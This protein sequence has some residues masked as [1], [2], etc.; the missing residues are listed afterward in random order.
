MDLLD[1]PGEALF[2]AEARAWL[3]DHLAGEFACVAGAGGPGREHEDI[4]ARLAWE[5][6]LGEQG[7]SCLGWPSQW[8]GRGATI[9]EQVIW[10]EEY[11]AANAPARLGV[12]GEGLLGPTLIAHG[13]EAQKRRFLAPIRLGRELW[14]QGYSEPG[15]GSDLAGVTTRAVLEGDE[16]VI[17]G[18]KVWTSLAHLADWCFVVCRTDPEAPRHRGLSY[19]LV[20]MDQPGITVRPIYQMTGTSEFNE[21]FFDG[22]RTPVEM[23]VGKVNGGWGVALATLGYERGVAMLGHLLAFRRELEQVTELARRTGRAGNPVLR[24][25]LARAWSGLMVMRWNTL[26][27]LPGIDSPGGAQASI[28]K[29]FWASWHQELGELSMDLL[30][31]DALAWLAPEP[32]SGSPVPSYPLRDLHRTFLFSRAETIYGGS[33]EI[34]RN[35]IGERALGLPTEPKVGR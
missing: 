13:T 18:Q 5:R 29:L 35:V 27:A 14:C 4:E 9:A 12:L 32:G 30:G 15:A 24:Q 28:S 2:R 17:T 33:N 11:V 3:R 20:P 7:W 19:L 10:N 34:Q 6:L 1:T 22:A 26:R 23:V 16:W 8:G 31:A 25:R 21:V